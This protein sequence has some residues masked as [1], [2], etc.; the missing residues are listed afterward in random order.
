MD[1]S[2]MWN[3]ESDEGLMAAEKEVENGEEVEDQ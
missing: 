2:Q 1:D 3:E